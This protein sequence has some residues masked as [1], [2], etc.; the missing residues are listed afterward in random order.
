LIDLV[1]HPCP[2]G[3]LGTDEDN[4]NGRVLQMPVDH[5]SNG[6]RPSFLCI[7]VLG[8]IEEAGDIGTGDHVGVAHLIRAPDIAFVV[9]A[10]ED[11]PCHGGEEKMMESSTVPRMA[12]WSKEIVGEK[13]VRR[14]DEVREENGSVSMEYGWTAWPAA[15]AVDTA[16]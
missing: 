4:G 13:T 16:S 10:E 5:A 9:E 12:R 8:M 3:G 11:A 7:F 1:S 2:V 6:V 15:D 14:V